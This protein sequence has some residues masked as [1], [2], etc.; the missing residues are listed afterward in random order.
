MNISLIRRCVSIVSIVQ[1]R[2]LFLTTTTLGRKMSVS[3]F[4]YDNILYNLPND[5]DYQLAI[6]RSHSKTISLEFFFHENWYSK[7]VA[8]V[9]ESIQKRILSPSSPLGILK[10]K[11]INIQISRTIA[12]SKQKLSLKLWNFKYWLGLPN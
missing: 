6:G 2:Q 12:F 4:F 1:R 11:H 5:D 8:T 7:N 9:R 3:L 10:L